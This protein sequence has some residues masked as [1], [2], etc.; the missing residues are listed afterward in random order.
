M[1]DPTQLEHKRERFCRTQI[2]AMLAD[3]NGKILGEVPTTV[4]T[5]RH[6][7][8]WFLTVCTSGKLARCRIELPRLFEFQVH[9]MTGTCLFWNT[10]TY[11]FSR[12][13][14]G[15]IEKALI[16]PPEAS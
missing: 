4:A 8:P 5:L 7:R 15:D 16:W 3:P 9:S 11:N 12:V 1:E 13:K 14:T 6:R 2:L 10:N